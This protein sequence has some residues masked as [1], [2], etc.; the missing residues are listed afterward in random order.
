[1]SWQVA[2]IFTGVISALAQIVGKRQVSKMGA[3]QGGVIRDASTLLL[4]SIILLFHGGIPSGL[5]WQALV[6]F[7]VG[8][9]ESVSMA[10]YFAAQRT[11]MAATAVFSYP[12]SQLLIILLSGIAF[13]EGKYFDV[14]TL[15]GLANTIALILTM[16]LTI[17]YQA[18]GKVGGRLRWSNALVVSAIIV[19]IS[20]LESKWAVSTLHYT[21]AQAMIYEYAGLLSGG[22]MYVKLRKQ[23]LRV[24]WANLGWGVAQGLLYGVSAFWYIALLTDHPL[25]ISSVMRRVTIVL[26]TVVAGLWGWGERRRLTWRQGLALALGIVVFGLVMGVNR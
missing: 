21:P 12:A 18:K 16:A 22:L 1:M 24:G 11:E 8:L 2:V 15:V 13:G 17:I 25:G 3:F 9:A 4:V 5:P 14:R 19:A 10:L 26:M 7:G 23:T 6:I 20:N